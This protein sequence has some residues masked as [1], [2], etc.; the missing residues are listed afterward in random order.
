MRIANM[1]GRLTLLTTAGPVDVATASDGRFGPDPQA[2]YESFD[3]FSAWAA[4]QG[5]SA[6]VE[7]DPATLGAPAPAP[8]QVFAIGLNYRDHAAEAG[9]ALPDDPVVFT[10]FPSSLAGPDIAV[11]LPSGS[12]DWEV[13]LVAVISRVAR[14][15]TVER[16]WEYVAGLTVGQ[17]LS[18][19][20]LQLRGPYPQFSLGKS[21]PGFSPIGPVL[22][23]PDELADPD[24]LELGCA[25][26]GEQLQKSRTAEMIFPVP[27]L[28]SYLSSI[29]TLY[30]GDVIFTG[31]PSGVGVARAPQRFL[32]PGDELRSWI[33][34]I[35]EIRQRFQPQIP[36]P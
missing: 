26:N 20:Q 18:E 5:P 3:E 29:V 1:R 8:R 15:V 28:V 11:P 36:S 16:A 25:V 7:L 2:A 17:D 30:P 35:G 22:V 24:D 14:D 33:E 32:R 34:G 6:A 23:T 21:H 9:S 27:R 31:T 13:E 12:V 10:K 4:A 19:R